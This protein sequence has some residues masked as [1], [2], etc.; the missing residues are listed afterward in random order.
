[1]TAGHQRGANRLQV[2]GQID[3]ADLA[4]RRHDGADRKIAEAHD[5]RDHF[6]FAGFEHAGILGFDDEGADFILADFLAGLA[7]VAEQPQQC[8]AGAIESQTAGNEIV[9]SIVM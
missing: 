6:L 1:M 9:A 7:A 8:L 5:A 3:H 4:A 2:I